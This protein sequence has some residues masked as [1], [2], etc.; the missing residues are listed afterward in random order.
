M[1][2]KDIEIL[3]GKTNP[4][5][6]LIAPHGY[7]DPDNDENTGALAREMQKILDCPAII[8]EVYR[9]PR[10]IS[11]N[12]DIYEAP[13][14]GAKILDLNRREHA[15]MHP[16]FIK[17]IEKAIEHPESTFV[18]WIHGIEGGNLEEESKKVGDQKPLGC[19]IGYGQGKPERQSC[20]KESVD[21]LIQAF[22]STGIEAAS[23]KWNSKKYRGYHPENM[24]QW[25]KESGNGL[26]TVQSIQLE[27]GFKGLR[28]PKSVDKTAQKLAGALLT[29]NGTLKIVP[30]EKTPDK[31]LVADSLNRL[32][33]L[34]N[35]SYH[36]AMLEA[37]EYIIKEFFAGNHELARNPRN[38][39][40]IESLN[41]LIKRLQED[42]GK[43][44]SKTWVYDAVKLA[45]DEHYFA[46]INFRTYGKGIHLLPHTPFPESNGQKGQSDLNQ[47]L[48]LL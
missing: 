48:P 32:S 11:E 3:E 5:V 43:A 35:G 25:F 38:A 4:H 39:V 24:N 9:K 34:F 33:E 7:P 36:E 19:L 16:T 42:D 20:D 41:Q 2:A 40:K 13:S 14:L 17:S 44:P 46:K 23:T 10:K 28:D 26:K 45:V 37:G 1:P 29:L 21:R 12:P 30:F 18:F 31:S 6:L 22:K 8:N 47:T 15:E 27:F